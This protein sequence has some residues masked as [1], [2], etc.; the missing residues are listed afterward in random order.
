MYR[1]KHLWIGLCRWTVATLGKVKT[2]K[3]KAMK[4]LT[5]KIDQIITQIDYLIF[6]MERRPVDRKAL[7]KCVEEMTGKLSE[8]EIS[9]L[10]NQN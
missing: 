9:E 4:D 1:R 5:E 2:P 8:S 7:T 3:T 6:I 10:L